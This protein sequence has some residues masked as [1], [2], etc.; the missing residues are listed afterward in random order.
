MNLGPVRTKKHPSDFELNTSTPSSSSS[1]WERQAD[2]LEQKLQHQTSKATRAVSLR[3]LE[4]FR[5]EIQGR[6][7]E[8]L[9]QQDAAVA[10]FR[11]LR[12]GLG[13]VGRG[14]SWCWGAAWDLGVRDGRWDR[15]RER[16]RVSSPSWR[17]LRLLLDCLA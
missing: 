7:F 8:N 4:S 3:Q 15:E 16:R 17:V 1:Q 2:L 10:R 11:K 13:L 12:T 9:R 14:R 5:A 6:D